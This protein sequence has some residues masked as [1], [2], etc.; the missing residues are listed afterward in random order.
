MKSVCFKFVSGFRKSSRWVYEFRDVLFAFKTFKCG[1]SE[2]VP[3]VASEQKGLL[4][5]I[6]EIIATRDQCKHGSYG[7]TNRTR[8]LILGDVIFAEIYWKV[9]R[10]EDQGWKDGKEWMYVD[11]VRLESIRV[12][13]CWSM[14][15]KVIHWV[16]RLIRSHHRSGCSDPRYICCT[17]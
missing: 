2:V 1:V 6:V 10:W 8:W 13:R 9:Q 17:R 12:R 7:K 14:V 11:I 4:R 3:I 16:I 15:R 5:L